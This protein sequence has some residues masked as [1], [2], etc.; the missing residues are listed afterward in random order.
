M[1]DL[2]TSFIARRFNIPALAVR[3]F[4][5]ASR[6]SGLDRKTL[7]VELLPLNAIQM[8]RGILNF[9]V[10]QTLDRWVLP[11]WAE[12]QYDPLA[13]EFIPRAHLGISMNLT[14]RNWTAAGHPSSPIEPIMDPRGLVTPHPDGWSI[15][16]WLCTAAATIF[17]SRLTSVH[18]SL[19]DAMP[20]VRTSWIVD[21]IEFATVLYTSSHC[22]VVRYR[23]TNTLPMTTTATVGVA[24]RPFNPEGISLIGDVHVSPD[25]LT[26]Y[27]NGVPGITVD[28]TPA[29]VFMSNH[30]RGDVAWKFAG[31]LRDAGQEAITCPSGL[32]TAVLLFDMLLPPGASDEIVVTS[33][34]RGPVG[35]TVVSV[36][37]AVAEWKQ[38]CDAG[39][40]A[41]LPG[42]DLGEIFTASHAALLAGLDGSSIRPGPATYHYFWFRDAAYMLLALDR[43]GHGALTHAVFERFPESQDR[44]GMF[45]SQQGEWDS[46]GQVLWSVWQHAVLTHDTRI[47]ERHFTSLQAGV[48]WIDKKR[49]RGEGHPLTDGLLPRGLSAEHLGLAD[50]YYWDMFWSLAGVEAFERICDLLGRRDEAYDAHRLAHGMR[51]DLERSIETA[52]G[53]VGTDAIP[54][55]PLRGIDA[56][57]IGTTVAW[58][59]LQVFPPDD[60]RMLATVRELLDRWFIDGMFY[61]PFVHSGLNA[62]LTL[63]VAECMLHAGDA[64]R[65]WSILEDVARHATSTGTFPEAIHPRTGGGCMGDGHHLWAAAEVLMLVRNAFVY[66]IWRG[67]SPVH[68]IRYLAGIPEA[69]FLQGGSFGMHRVPI[70]EGSV[71]VVVVPSS[72]GAKITITLDRQGRSPS[73]DWELSLPAS[74]GAATVDGQKLSSTCTPHGRRLFV[75]PPRSIEIV[76][77]W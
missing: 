58:H 56:G 25:C 43:L 38:R 73:G 35:T 51:R 72:A 18:Q 49:M 76:A 69:P 3:M 54:A 8:S 36:E 19:I 5:A 44:D 55:G 24:I 21:G 1:S 12:R 32:C 13:P 67:S 28:R 50:V 9:T 74:F 6:L 20:V 61:Q 66:E 4:R 47:P 41:D 42:G 70:P 60:A 33:P 40:H 57:I 45:R 30:E 34:L 53:Y 23:V 59:P 17:P 22:A 68:T 71:D 14:H 52:R 64:E 39:V 75:L 46:T 29:R 65:A 63:H 15:D 77:C 2:I 10:L 16:G 26:L 31:D 62:Y 48:R 7:P 27:V 11:F 37:R